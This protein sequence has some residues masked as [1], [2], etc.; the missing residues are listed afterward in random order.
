MWKKTLVLLYLKIYPQH[1]RVET[2]WL[3]G[4]RWERRW[5]GRM[6][7]CLVS[8]AAWMRTRSMA[9]IVDSDL[10]PPAGIM[11]L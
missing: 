8:L 3:Y 11:L 7:F 9:A 1:R 6:D 2:F 5:R 4:L 10:N